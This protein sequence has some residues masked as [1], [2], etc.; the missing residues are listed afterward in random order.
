MRILYVEDEPDIRQ[1]AQ[2]ALEGVGG[3]TVHACSSGAEALSVLPQFKPDLILL[4]VMMPGIDGPTTLA[5]L[6]ELPGAEGIPAVFMTAKVQPHEIAELKAIGALDVIPKP[7]D[8]MTLSQTVG[9][10]WARSAAPATPSTDAPQG[11]AVPADELER[12][13]D[14]FAAAL[15]GKLE[16][17]TAL[18]QS[19]SA[20]TVSDETRETLHRKV[21]TLTGSAKTFGFPLLSDAARALEQELKPV[22]GSTG[23][24]ADQ[25]SRM[26][27][28][29][30][31]L[32]RATQHPRAPLQAPAKSISAAASE[33]VTVTE[34][35]KLVY[36]LRDADSRIEDIYAAL[37]NSGYEIGMFAG[38]EDLLQACLR[39]PP[40]AVIADASLAQPESGQ[41]EW[42]DRLREALTK[43]PALIFVSD[44]DDLS[45]RLSA[46]R[47]GGTAYFV[48]PVKPGSLVD[49][50]DELIVSGPPDPY[51]VAIVEDSEEQAAFCAAVLQEA[52]MLTCV[53]S[54]PSQLLARLA[55]FHPELVLMDMYLPGCTGDELARVVR[56]MDA[57]VSL[58]I[59]FLSVEADFDR[60]L[61]AMGLGG[62]EFLTK[63][64]LP[65]HL[66]SI[67]ISRVERYR[68]LRALMV[69]D[70]L[71][72]LANHSRLHQLLETEVARA[73]R[74][75]RPLA[76]AMI[77]V[78]HFKQVNDSHGHPTGDRVLQQLARF[79]RQ[80]LRQ[81]DVV[82]RYGGEEF[83]VVL[84]NTNAANGGAVIDK[85]RGKFAI[86]EHDSDK[87]VPFRVTF[88]AGVT[89]LFGRSTARDMVLAA[90]HALY[91]AK[92]RGRN[93]VVSNPAAGQGAAQ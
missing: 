79:L 20:R 38:G 80:R 40:T 89:G 4:D 91:Q 11:F 29:L 64:I 13:A 66:K 65:G 9:S 27:G 19:L 26:D 37:E 31:A 78:D 71:T 77:D 14:A 85:L 5:R 24:D 1:V 47:A 90:D 45:N 92:D 88:S 42:T 35:R 8:P 23:P 69:Q 55:E 51:R 56:Q 10:I 61:V 34:P 28:L 82:A 70:S 39:R 25:L 81:T 50:L 32:F 53:V 48:R 33:R 59:V 73:V 83:A 52:G 18:Y 21:H 43:P 17:I 74:Q 12:I 15:P 84:S 22:P 2:M 75:H 44:R 93:C 76:L 49:R 72:G 68:T 3:F 36:A 16:E 6:R 63:P 30:D 67:V 46:A 87:G 54:E 62:D 58:P 41:A 7:F 86:L 60:Q 57:Y